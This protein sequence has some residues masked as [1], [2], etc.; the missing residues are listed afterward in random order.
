VNSRQFSLQSFIRHITNTI[1]EDFVIDPT[2][3]LKRL[4]AAYVYSLKPEEVDRLGR[5]SRDIVEE[6][7]LLDRRIKTLWD[8]RNA[9]RTVPIK[10]GNS[11]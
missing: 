5:E 9:A 6:R 4:S 8:A 2:G 11:V 7:R 10:T 1:V 3:P